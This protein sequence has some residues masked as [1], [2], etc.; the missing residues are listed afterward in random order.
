M[1]QLGP[2]WEAFLSRLQ[3]TPE[4]M[5]RDMRR[6]L[7]ASLLLIEADART[8]APQDTRRLSGSINNQI[9]GTFPSLVGEVGPG[10]RYG[11]FVEFGRRAGARM[12]P[13]DA[14]IGWVRRHW[15]PIEER[16]RGVS[17]STLRGEAFVLARSIARRGIQPQPFMQRAYQQ[18]RSRIVTGFAR[19]G[20]R[21]VAYLSGQPLP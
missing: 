19:L 18:N 5:E 20:L 7:Q 15:H 13:V 10:V 17:R 16:R 1:I 14:L 21:T 4:Q 12:P 3:T 6:T 2:E 11:R 8:L 9:T